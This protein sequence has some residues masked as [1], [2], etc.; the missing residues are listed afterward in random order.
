MTLDYNM[1]GGLGLEP[2]LAESESAVNNAK[3]WRNPRNLRLRGMEAREIRSV[4]CGFIRHI[5]VTL[6]CKRPFHILSVFIDM[7]VGIAINCYL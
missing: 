7:I 4:I 2:R 6:V 5:I 3:N 1:A